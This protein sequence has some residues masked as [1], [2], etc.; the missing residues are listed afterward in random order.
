MKPSDLAGRRLG[1]WKNAP[2]SLAGK[3]YRPL[4]DH[5]IRA[6]AVSR[7]DSKIHE[8]DKDNQDDCSD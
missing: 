3:T 2:V 7:R 4:I 5:Q 1:E 6:A 8:D